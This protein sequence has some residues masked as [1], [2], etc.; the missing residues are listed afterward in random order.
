MTSIRRIAPPAALLFALAACGSPNA[1][2]DANF[3]AA[4]DKHFSSH[5]L[6]ISPSVGLTAYPATIDASTDA[7]R[8]DAL[9]AAGLLTASVAS[10]EHPG[11]LGIGTT[12]STSKTYALTDAGRTAFNGDAGANGGFCAGH[13]D[14]ASV[15]NFTAPTANGGET[16][17][18]VTFTV[19]P[20]WESWV[21]NPAVQDRYG[22]QLTKVQRTQDHATLVQMA[23]G[24]VVQGDAS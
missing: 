22:A 18:Q 24:W 9:V 4:L 13:Y 3:K 8:F 23:K 7:S 16:V 2:N 12:R 15:D 10:N 1:A 5:C 17:S 20:H 19:D 14:V 21:S 6:F 11:P